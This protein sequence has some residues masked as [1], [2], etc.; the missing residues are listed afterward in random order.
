MLW[1]TFFIPN[2][3]IIKICFQSYTG[4]IDYFLGPFSVTFPAGVISVPFNVTLVDDDLVE[5]Y[6][7][8]TLYI[9][10]SSLPDNVKRV[11]PYSVSV[12]IVDDDSKCLI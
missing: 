9:D 1:S 3:Y 5:P 2:S 8:F 4:G 6:E 11:Y 10:T 7:S 12:T